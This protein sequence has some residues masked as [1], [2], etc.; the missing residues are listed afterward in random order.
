MPIAIGQGVTLRGFTNED[1]QFTWYLSGTAG[2]SPLTL[3]TKSGALPAMMIDS[4]ADATAKVAT[5]GAVILGA[6]ETFEN[7]VQEGVIVGTL[8][9]KANLV[10]EYTGTAPTRGHGVVGSATPGKVK[11]AA[12]AVVGNIVVEVDTVNLTVTVMFG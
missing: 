11:T 3:V 2:V 9:H 7:R 10:F 12:A 1:H 8:K 4:T 6:L 5:D